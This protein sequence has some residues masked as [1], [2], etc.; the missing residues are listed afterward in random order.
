MPR[1]EPAEASE[2]LESRTDSEARRHDRTSSRLL[3]RTPQHLLAGNSYVRVPSAFTH[4]E[5]FRLQL[6]L[7]FMCS[8]CHTS[9]SLLVLPS[10]PH[11]FQ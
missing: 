9:F 10:S 4:S 7:V 11:F 6:M 1:R 2:L 8:L 5:L 3:C